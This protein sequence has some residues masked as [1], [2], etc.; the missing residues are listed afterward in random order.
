MNRLVNIQCLRAVAAL[1]VVM[2]HCGLEMT[3]IAAATGRA[4]VFDHERWHGGVALFFTISG[5]IMVVTCRDAFGRSGEMAAFLSRRLK[6][7]VPIYWLL[8]LAMTALYLVAPGLIRVPVEHASDIALSFLFWPFARPDG[9][10]RPLVTPG[11]TLNLEVY[12]Y[13]VFAIGLMF[14]RAVGL[15]LVIAFISLLCLLRINGAFTV[16]PL[17]FW[18]DPI[19]LGFVFGMLVGVV[20]DRGVRFGPL[21]AFM[22]IAAGLALILTGGVRSL[23]EDALLARLAESLPATMVLAGAA[24]GPQADPAKT[25]WRWL[26]AIGDA[27]YSLYLVHEF[28][29]RPMRLAWTAMIGDAVP[30]WLFLPAGIGVSITAG[31]LSYHALE[32]PIGRWLTRREK[33]GISGPAPFPRARAVRT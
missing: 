20:H 31:L 32:R 13:A 33:R 28:L 9:D 11:W 16:V 15:A 19:V 10:V 4:P 22:L 18:G 23:P 17:L 6:R 30:L 2:F 27:S 7:I 5:F 12:F 3:R 8:T 25:G 14:R 21:P 26:V 1:F 29:L 24:L